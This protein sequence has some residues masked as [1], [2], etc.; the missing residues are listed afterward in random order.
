MSYYHVCTECGAALDPGEK[1][2]DCSENYEE[3]TDHENDTEK[4]THPELQRV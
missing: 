4:N 3:D 1:C 2:I